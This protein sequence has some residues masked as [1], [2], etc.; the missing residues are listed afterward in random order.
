M[1]CDAFHPRWFAWLSCELLE[2][3]AVLLNSME[4]VGAWPEQLSAILIAFIPKSNGGTQQI[5]LLAGLVRLWERVR[6]PI[7]ADWRKSVE[8]TYNWA[9]KGKSPQVAVWRLALRAEAARARGQELAATL[10]DLA[11][12]MGFPSENL[13]AGAG[14]LR[15]REALTA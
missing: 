8:R 2:A 1:G 10:V 14:G 6:K 7:V 9:A 15:V 12:A 13:E 4:R 11:K 5:G 3:F